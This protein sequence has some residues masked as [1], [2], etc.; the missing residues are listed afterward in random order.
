MLEIHGLHTHYGPSHI[1]Q[2][3]DLAAGPGDVIG[4]F[5]RNGVGKT[6]LLKTIAAGSRRARARYVLQ[7]GG[8][9]AL[10]PIKSA[11]PASASCRRIAASSLP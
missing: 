5:G 6:T 1:V 3:I 8:S 2:G 10:R 11:A 4:I 7:A 9:M